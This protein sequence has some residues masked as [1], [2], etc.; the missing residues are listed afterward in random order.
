MS[1]RP[2]PGFRILFGVMT[3]RF[4]I[5]VV[6]GSV[7]LVSL[8]LLGGA[9]EATAQWQGVSQQATETVTLHVEGMT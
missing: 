1:A 7:I 3:R 5:S 4:S 2:T 8:V 6:Y 9:A